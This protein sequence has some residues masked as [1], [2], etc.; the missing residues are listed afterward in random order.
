MARI[1][2]AICVVVFGG[3]LAWVAFAT[4]T[5]PEPLVV[6]TGGVIGSVETDPLPT[7]P[8]ARQALAA[9]AALQDWRAESGPSPDG[10]ATR[11]QA[12]PSGMQTPA[13]EEAAV[14]GAALAR[15][16]LGDRERDWSLLGERGYFEGT[17][18]LPPHFMSVLEQ[19]QGRDFRRRHESTI[20]YSGGWI[21]FG[22][23][24]L[25]SLFLLLRGRIRIV[26]GFSGVQIL[27]FD[28]LER[29]NHWMTAAGFVVLG[30]TGLILIYGWWLLSPLLGPGG[31]SV[32]AQWSLYLHIAFAGPFVI[33]F[34]LMAVL[35]LRQNLPSRLDLHWLARFGGFLSDSPD[36]PSARRFNAGQK[37]VF[38]G[39]FL[40]GLLMTASGLTLMFPFFFTGVVALQWVLLGHALLALLLVA[41]ILGHIYIGTVGMEGAFDAMWDGYV[42]RNWAEEH[43][44]L[45]LEE[46]EREHPER[47]R[48][49]P[50]AV[51]AE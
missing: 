28:A 24:L 43:H 27:R 11:E 7:G 2:A 36:K 49:A 15:Q 10:A 30:L 26:E 50:D 22:M 6:P 39:V 46:I 29:A 38:W 41:L 12:A 35:W 48:T 44:D 20:S 33:G 3:L 4:F 23:S 47:M 5:K 1:A 45:W 14:S 31:F 8:E 18:S 40:G 13:D 51:P 19:P 21:I 32:L 25:L 9:R 17:V 16:W 42:D 34:M 37:L